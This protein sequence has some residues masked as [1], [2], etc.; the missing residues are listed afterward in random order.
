MAVIGHGHPTAEPV[1]GCDALMTQ[2]PGVALLIRTAD[3]LP[4]FFSHPKRKVVALAHAGWRGLALQLPVRVLAGFWDLYRCPAGAIEVAI[5]PAIR[6][7]C[8]QVGPE[9]KKIFGPAVA[10]R[11]GRR[12]CDLI[13][14]AIRQLQGAGVPRHNIWDTGICTSCANRRWYSLRR[15]GPSTGRLTSLIMVNR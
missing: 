14:V 11:N 12:T 15:E 5:G 10:A 9:F 13:G 7:C 1:A 8:Y 2:R 3:C 4:I 6:S